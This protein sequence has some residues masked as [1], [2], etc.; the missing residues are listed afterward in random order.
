MDEQIAKI[1]MEDWEKYR[2][3]YEHDLF[4]DFVASIG[5]ILLAV[6]AVVVTMLYLAGVFG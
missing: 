2:E 5:T 1:I 4:I 3:E 6:T